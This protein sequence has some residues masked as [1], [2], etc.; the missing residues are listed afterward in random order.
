MVKMKPATLTHEQERKMEIARVAFMVSSP[1]YSHLYYSLGREVFTKDIPTA[2]TDGR[3]ILL[4]PD[5]VCG[6]TVPEQVFILAHEMSHL[7]SQHPTRMVHYK[8][9]DKLRN[10]PYDQRFANVCADYCINADLVETGIG[11]INPAWLFDK[12][13]KGSEL[14]EDVYERLFKPGMCPPPPQRKGGGQ[15]GRKGD[16]QALDGDGTFDEI[17]EPSTDADGGAD[18][19]SESE[20]KEA[21]AQAYAV[22]K[23]MGDVPGSIQRMVEEILAPQIDWREHVRLLVTGKVGYRGETWTKPNR[24]RLVMNPITIMPGR[25]GHGCNT[26]VVGVDTSGSVGPDEMRVF[27]SELSGVLQD[28][29][30]KR[31]VVIGCDAAVSQVDELWSVDEFEALRVKGIKGGGG[32]RFEPVFDYVKEQDLRPEALIYLTDMEG[33][34]PSEAPAYPVIWAATGD[35]VGPFGD[36]VRIKI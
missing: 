4:N 36:T 16:Q 3:R 2:A 31:I 6:F 14:W 24:R 11:T 29:R 17:L 33:T 23:A 15:G 26:V 9:E 7:V 21:V 35:H 12:A 32:T 28:V 5:Y 27:M 13:I 1:F 8:R 10:L 25:N 18:L 30:P 34:F 20:F 22:A 19:P